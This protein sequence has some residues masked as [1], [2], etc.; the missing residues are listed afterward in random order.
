MV[1]GRNIRDE[2]DRLGPEMGALLS[3]YKRALPAADASPEFMPALWA[4]IEHRQSTTHG[5]RRM[6]SGFVTA[7]AAICLMLSVAL[8]APPNPGQTQT[9]GAY[10]DVL[11]DDT[12]DADLTQ[13]SL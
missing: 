12:A 10:I 13:E 9:V 2:Q 3:S 11:A 5:F 1:F 6:A 8:W 4:R 7:A